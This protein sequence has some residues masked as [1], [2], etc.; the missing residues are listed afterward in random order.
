MELGTS[1]LRGLFLFL[2]REMMCSFESKGGECEGEI[3]QREAESPWT[4]DVWIFIVQ[5]RGGGGGG[6]R[7]REVEG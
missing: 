1:E 2:F 7:E 6:E 3:G 4:Y 5:K